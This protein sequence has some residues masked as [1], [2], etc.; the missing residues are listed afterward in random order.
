MSRVWNEFSVSL[1]QESK[2]WWSW[3][4][5]TEFSIYLW[6]FN[7]FI[8]ITKICT[9][10]MLYL[11]FKHNC[12]F[13]CKKRRDF[14]IQQHPFHSIIFNPYDKL[15]QFWCFCTITRP[16]VATLNFQSNTKYWQML[17]NICWN[18]IIWQMVCIPPRWKFLAFRK[19]GWIL[20]L[21]YT[22]GICFER[23]RSS[24]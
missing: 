4:F 8:R 7:T 17:C 15:Q 1:N 21:S 16:S 19:C 6:S 5:I 2:D 24:K 9:V 20:S 10:A 22:S 14:I 13:L 12:H 18:F 11:P 23:G 3:N